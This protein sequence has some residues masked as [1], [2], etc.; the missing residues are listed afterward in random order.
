VMMM[1][2]VPGDATRCLGAGKAALNGECLRENRQIAPLTVFD[3]SGSHVAFLK[4]TAC[5]WLM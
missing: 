4:R 1:W 3:L 5:S 2:L